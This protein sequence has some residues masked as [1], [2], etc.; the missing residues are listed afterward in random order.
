MEPF[1]WGPY[2]HLFEL[3]DIRHPAVGNQREREFGGHR[4]GFPTDRAGGKIPILFAHDVRDIRRR[5]T[6]LRH[7]NRI[8]DQPHAVVLLS[9]HRRVTDARQALDV[10]EDAQRDK[11]REK[12]AS[13]CG[14]SDCMTMTA[15]RSGDI[16]LTVIPCRTT[17]GGSCGSASFWRFWAW[18]CAISTLVPIWNVS[19]MLMCPSFVLVESK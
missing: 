14:S 6:E 2:D 15:R 13:C 1:G 3:A 9:E 12:K 8:E 16:F 10:V 19:R 11:V 17:S 7:A 18:T 5:Q 4:H